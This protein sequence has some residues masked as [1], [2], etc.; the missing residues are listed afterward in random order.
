MRIDSRFSK[1]AALAA[2][3]LAVLA[4]STGCSK[5]STASEPIRDAPRASAVADV[6]PGGAFQQRHEGIL[7]DSDNRREEDN[8]PEDVYPIDLK[9][10][11]V[12]TVTM[13]SSEF[14]T[15]ILAAQ[16]DAS[17]AGQNDDCGNDETTNSCITFTAGSKGTYT[18]YANV[19]DPDGRGAYV[20][21]IDVAYP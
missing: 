17:E 13:T 4:F 5:K 21:D 12:V 3:V 1:P 8:S 19:A 20:L 16:P 7:T 14:D 15:Y 10:G 2:S 9:A 6:A 11:A 18:I